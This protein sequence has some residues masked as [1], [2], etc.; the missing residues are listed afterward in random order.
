MPTMYDQHA[1]DL[2]EAQ[3]AAA[4]EIKGRLADADDGE[5][6]AALVLVLEKAGVDV[7]RGAWTCWRDLS[8][9]SDEARVALKTDSL[10]SLFA[11][12]QSASGGELQMS[13]LTDGVSMRLE[14]R[15]LLFGT[16]VLLRAVWQA[17]GM[18]LLKDEVLL[19]GLPVLALRHASNAAQ[20]ESVVLDVET[21]WVWDNVMVGLSLEDA[22]ACLGFAC[23]SVK[24]RPQRER[25]CFEDVYTAYGTQPGCAAHLFVSGGTPDE[26]ARMLCET[27]VKAVDILMR[28]LDMARASVFEGEGKTA[29][30]QGAC[31]S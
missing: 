29:F 25:G 11:A 6:A 31:A 17:R 3:A 30:L 24:D 15:V 23:R 4:I 7:P 26:A 22:A 14:G 1:Y 20:S 27:S 21:N 8:A 9:L 16:V 13:M 18:K 28:R 19:K 12:A 10:R 2:H 5:L